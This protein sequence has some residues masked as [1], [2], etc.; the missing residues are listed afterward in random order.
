MGMMDTYK[1]DLLSSGLGGKTFEYDLSDDFFAEMEGLVQRG[2]IHTTV[3][4]LSAGSVYKFQIH[5]VGT[6]IVPCDR[7]L[8]DLEL[9]IETTDDLNVKLGDEYA[10]EGDCVVV[11][12][13]EGYLDLAQFIYEF[14]ALSMP[15][16]CCHEPG[17]CDDAMM[18]ELSKHQ[19]TRSGV[20]DDEQADSDLG[21]AED[22]SMGEDSDEPVDSRWAALKQF[23]EQLKK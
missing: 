8:S 21:D 9:R 18:H 15:L 17:K 13:A 11:P 14:I 10:D 23:K 3:A 1:I 12:E 19:S 4:C 7:C 5:S 20:A 2:S 6:I 22:E 16:T